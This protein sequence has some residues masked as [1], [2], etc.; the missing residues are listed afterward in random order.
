MATVP[1]PQPNRVLGSHLST[2]LI[3]LTRALGSPCFTRD[4]TEAQ[5]SWGHCP[6]PTAGKDPDPGPSHQACVP[7]TAPH[8]RAQTS[9]TLAHWSQPA[10]RLQPRLRVPERTPE[11]TRRCQCG[12]EA[13]SFPRPGSH[14]R[15][16]E[17]WARVW[18]SCGPAEEGAITRGTSAPAP[19]PPW[20]LPSADVSPCH[21]PGARTAASVAL[22]ACPSATYMQEPTRSGPKVPLGGL[23]QPPV[24]RSPDVKHN[25]PYG[26]VKQGVCTRQLAQ[27]RPRSRFLTRLVQHVLHTPPVCAW[28][29][30]AVLAFLLLSALRV[31]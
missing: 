2:P 5:G 27:R 18:V 23:T 15:K 6:R 19:H 21:F 30:D 10:L 29:P 3:P 8:T 16:A 28:A 26:A 25:L 12:Q 14:R 31:T 4:D 9:N 20:H 7:L 11:S 1:L 24:P 22:V 17:W 13:V